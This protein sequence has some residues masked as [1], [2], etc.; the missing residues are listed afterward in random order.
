MSPAFRV[1]STHP[2][3]IACGQMVGPGEITKNVNP[4]HA[5]DKRLIEEG[6][7]VEQPSKR[8]PQKDKKQEDSK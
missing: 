2:E 7:L 1:C 5:H 6:V 8:P 3:D 4:K